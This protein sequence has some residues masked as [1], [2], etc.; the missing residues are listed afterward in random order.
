MKKAKLFLPFLLV[1][2]ACSNQPGGKGE[3]RTA[4]GDRVYG[5]TFHVNETERYSSLMPIAVTDIIASNICLQIYEG[6]VRLDPKTLQIR[7][8]LAE[9]WETDPSGMVYTFHL[10][11][12]VK[13]HD[14]P[15]FPGGK[16]REM[17]ATDVKY[18]FE[19]LCT[20][21][22][23]NSNFGG[24][25]KDRVKGANEFYN[26]KA[27]EVEGVKVK[28]DHTIE[29]AL[30]NPSQSFLYI[31]ANPAAAIVAKEAVDK[32]GIDLKNGTGPFMVAKEVKDDKG[33]INKLYLSRNPN[34][35]MSDSLGNQLPYLDSIMVSFIPSKNA[36]LEAFKSGE[37]DAVFGLP[38]DAISEM[39]QN[40]VNAFQNKP[41]LYV[42]DRTPELA[43]QYYEFVAV[44]PPFNNPKVRKAFCYA[45]DREKIIKDILNGE[46]YM[47]GTYGICPPG[48]PGY[49]TSKIKGYRF[50]PEKAKTMLKEAGYPGGKGF[51]AVKIELN[52]GGSKHTRVVE[53][54]QKQLKE[55]LNVNVDFDVVP[56][57]QK[58][59][60]AKHARADIF[61]SAWIADYP[62]PENFLWTLYGGT[63]PDSLEKPSF[64]NTP[65]YKNA[66]YDKL[67]DMGRRAKSKEE[68]YDAF[69]QAEQ[70]M[71]DDAP[72]LVL[73]YDENLKLAH[74]HV[75]NF[76]F[77]PMNYRALREVYIK[78]ESKTA[79]EAKK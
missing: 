16:G 60:D 9:K 8:A 19:L 59:D 66:D 56:F 12:G 13:F 54:I 78:S 67:F 31:L 6:M 23:E 50:D 68:A 30:S 53:E 17:T 11:K 29:I 28:D 45:I 2:A 35:Y 57:Q 47:A 69:A 37:L 10:Q 73:W 27:K 55:V 44:R 43:S 36:E 5:G 22:V 34:Y 72:I 51:P 70:K 77:N 15:C 7:P 1:L 58:L 33:N 76:F 75:K 65:R 64:P 39:V 49:D 46:A 71:L 24:T 25:F 62:S 48:I 21:R 18:S 79:G 3:Q 38:S 42:L 74:F 14:D 61:R 52:S 41:P 4:K 63:V 32:Y 40:N 26:G 20:N